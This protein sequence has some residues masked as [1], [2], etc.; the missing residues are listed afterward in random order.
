M[1]TLLTDA[2]RAWADRTYPVHQVTVT[3]ND[4]RRFAYAT[5]ETDPVH[6]DVE[7]ARAAGYPDLVAPPMFYVFLRVQPNHLRPRAELEADG[8][9]GEDIP[10]VAIRGAMAGATTLEVTREFVSGDEISCHKRL[11]GAVEKTG[12][13]GPLLF[14]TFEYRYVDAEGAMVVREEFTRILR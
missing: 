8:S 9:P 10:P 7:A 14:L 12:S 5:G 2:T 1:G 4:I 6:F 3:A 11:I 13:S